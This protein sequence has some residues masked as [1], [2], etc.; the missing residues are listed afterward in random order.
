[1]DKRQP[2][3]IRL[4]SIIRVPFKNDCKNTTFATVGNHTCC[5]Q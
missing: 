4:I 1:M 5:S 2:V 3:N